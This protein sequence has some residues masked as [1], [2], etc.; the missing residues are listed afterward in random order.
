MSTIY[1][2]TTEKGW[3]ERGRKEEGKERKR[4]KKGEGERRR[5][6]K[7]EGERRRGKKGEGERRRGKK[8]AGGRVKRCKFSQN[9]ATYLQLPITTKFWNAELAKV[10]L[11]SYQLGIS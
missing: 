7:G 3:E 1:Y 8:G 2:Q 4:G 10:I 6:K 5:G 9:I 11:S